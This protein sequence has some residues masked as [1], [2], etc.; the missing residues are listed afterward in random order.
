MLDQKEVVDQ[1]YKNK[2]NLIILIAIAKQII[3]NTLRNTIIPFLPKTLDNLSLNFN[4][5][6][7]TIKF[8]IIPIKIV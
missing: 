4:V 8:N 7:T 5:I 2:L 6:Y 1:N 3:P